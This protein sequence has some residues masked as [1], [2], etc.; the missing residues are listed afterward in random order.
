MDILLALCMALTPVPMAAEG[1][2][3][4]SYPTKT[5]YEIDEIDLMGYAAGFELSRLLF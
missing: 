2:T 3:I 5:E 4:L 1:V